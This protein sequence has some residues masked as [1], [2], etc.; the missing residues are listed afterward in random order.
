MPASNQAQ[1]ELLPP[2]IAPQ[3]KSA[4]NSLNSSD[5]EGRQD[6]SELADAVSSERQQS[7]NQTSTSGDHSAP[8]EGS[9][10]ETLHFFG[11]FDG[12]GG[13]EAA[14]HCAQTLHLR[15]SEALAAAT[16][17]PSSGELAAVERE[18]EAIRPSESVPVGIPRLAA[19]SAEGESLDST[20]EQLEEHF[21]QEQ[22]ANVL[23][24]NTASFESALTSAFNRTD[25]EFGKADN[26]ALVGTTA[27]VTLVGSRQ[28][29]VANCGKFCLCTLPL[30]LKQSASKRLKSLCVS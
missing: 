3:V 4:S 26:A 6:A 24:C 25:E 5:A 15:I 12:H 19:D 16:E 27:V 20:R 7:H 13:A 11:V 2:R 8:E 1:P 21:Y 14:L 28:L 10:L 18:G 17:L 23:T 22:G 30:L 9:Y 29:Y